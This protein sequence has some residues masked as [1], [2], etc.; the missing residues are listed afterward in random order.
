MAD[1]IRISTQKNKKEEEKKNIIN[2]L[3]PYNVNFHINIL[4]LE[5][6]YVDGSQRLK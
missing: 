5:R 3:I 6:Q 4:F 2:N 1:K